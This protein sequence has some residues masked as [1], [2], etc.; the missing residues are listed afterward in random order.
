MIEHVADTRGSV[1]TLAVTHKAE[2]YPNTIAS[3][4]L[5]LLSFSSR[6]ILLKM[7]TFI[8]SISLNILSAVNPAF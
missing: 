5:A 8:V 7:F 4:H 1:F 2:F 6:L 3:V